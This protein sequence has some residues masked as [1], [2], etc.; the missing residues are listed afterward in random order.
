MK[1]LRQELEYLRDQAKRKFDQVRATWIDQCRWAAPDRVKWLLSE[2]E[3]ERNNQHIVDGTHLLAL[4]SFIAGFMEGNTSSTRPWYRCGTADQ[5]RNMFPANH[6]WL[7]LFTRR[8]LSVLSTSNFYHASGFFYRD[9]GVVD[10]ASYLIDEV[11]EPTRRLHFHVL[12][13]GSYYVLNNALGEAIVLV[14]ERSMTVKA[15]VD[16]FGK[17][18]A[19][20]SFDWSNISKRVREMYDKGNYTQM[21]D[22]V[23]VCKK[24]DDY[25]PEGPIAAL[26]TPWIKYTYEL[27]GTR[28]QYY[29]DGR[30]YGFS[31]VDPIDKDVYLEIVG[32][33]RKPFVVGRAG[34][35]NFEY[36]ED[37]P[38]R[39]A[40]GCIK[41][42]NKKA[43]G[44]DQALEQ[45]LRPA[46]Q[47]PA[48]LRKSYIT[49]SPNSYVPL[50]ANSIARGAG[51]SRIV[52]IS[53]AISALVD[54][55][56]QLRNMVERFYFS[57]YLLFLSRNPKTRTAT[58]TDAIV[59][60][61]QL[62]IG[63][64]LQS[65]NWT[66]NVPI[67]DYVMD[68]VIE[69]DPFLPEPPPDLAGQFLRPEFISV[70]AQA[71]RA[72]D[73]PALER[74]VAWIANV[75]SI[76][77]R[78]FDKANLDRIADIYEDRL[79]LPAGVNR[80][81]EEVAAIRAKREAMA[82][83]QQQLNELTAAASAAKD[84]G[85]SEQIANGGGQL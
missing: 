26:N 14:L 73:L 43:I 28:G 74:Y 77:P 72:A 31:A 18:K 5:E 40:L 10:T 9:Y 19:D 23:T 82:A 33:R 42:L 55:V 51:L 29:Q 12:V 45:M 22:V 41:S 63:P 62:I 78:V 21:I 48:N 70:F 3:G 30:D 44:K 13:P 65:L 67:V 16:T 2:T 27:G 46:L 36:G 4:R 17:K 68:Y 34:A 7:D 79:Y 60:E 1:T 71:Q 84:V 49:S 64:Q 15:L 37:G 25:N 50:D 75:G 57:D 58:E 69:E 8:T 59:K 38:T 11:E 20:G 35:S 54:D 39:N 81:D 80:S 56:E 6:E 53:P 76:D 85:L 61:Q 24:N 47:G 83:R 52:E 32:R 66:H